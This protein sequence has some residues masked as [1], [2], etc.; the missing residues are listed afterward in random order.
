MPSTSRSTFSWS[1]S[2]SGAAISD[3]AARAAWP[4]ARAPTVR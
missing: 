4:A 3:R 1:L 2:R